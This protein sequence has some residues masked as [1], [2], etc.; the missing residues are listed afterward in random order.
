[1]IVHLFHFHMF[2]SIPFQAPADHWKFASVPP[3]PGLA[4]NVARSI[5]RPIPCA[6]TWRTSTPSALATDAFYAEPWPSQG[7]PCTRTC[8]VNTAESQPRTC[9]FCQCPAPSIR[10]LPPDYWPKLALRSH[11]QS[12]EPEHRPPAELDVMT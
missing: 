4:L 3:I 10:N 12:S 6:L 7:T 2:H 9:P 11:R 8:R 1:M 5:G